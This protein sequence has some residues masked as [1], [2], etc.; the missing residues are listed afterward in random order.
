M[1][2]QGTYAAPRADLGEALHEFR[3][4]QVQY[5]GTQLLPVLGVKKDK[6]TLSVVTRE[7]AMTRVDVKRAKR[8]AYNRAGLT[9]EDLE[10][11]TEEYGLEGPL[12]D[13]EREKYASDFDAELEVSQMTMLRVLREQEIRIKDL[14][15]NTTTWTGSDLYTDVSS[16]PWDAAGS[17]AIGHVRAAREKVR[18]ATGLEPDTMLIGKVTM[19]N[20]LAN[21]AIIARLQYV[22]MA[23]EQALRDALPEILGLKRILVGDHVY[24][25]TPEG[26]TISVTDI[27]ADDYAFIAVTAMNGG[28]PLVPCVGRTVL[29]ESD[30]PQNATVEQY[31]EEQTRSDIFRVRQYTDEKI[32]DPYFAHL[33]KVDA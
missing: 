20:L 6:A 32:F 22:A 33:L 4:T 7:D 12:E 10:Y 28:G 29:W 18:R 17:D 30:S 27:W 1:I 11:S 9:T 24:N 2:S 14:V 21:T 26:G 5:V 31:R 13:S 16:A 8:G 19:N 23:G 15:F 25:A 3:D